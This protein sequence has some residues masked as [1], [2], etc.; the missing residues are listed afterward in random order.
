MWSIELG[1]PCF[2]ILCSRAQAPE[3]YRPVHKAGSISG[4]CL[5]GSRPPTRLGGLAILN[6]QFLTAETCGRMARPERVSS[7]ASGQGPVEEG[8]DHGQGYPRDVQL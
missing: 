5:R 8:D 4:E 1:R 7:P 6:C 2:S 3:M